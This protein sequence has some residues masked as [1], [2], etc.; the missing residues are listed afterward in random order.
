MADLVKLAETACRP[1]PSDPRTPGESHGEQTAAQEQTCLEGDA[2]QNAPQR[3]RAP[4]KALGIAEYFCECPD[5]ENLRSQKREDN[6]ED[7]R[8]NVEPHVGRNLS[9]SR[10][11]PKHQKQ[12][13]QH[14]R[15]TRQKEK[16]VRGVKQHE[17]E[18]TPAVAKTA[19]MRCAPT[20]V[21]PQRD[22]NLRDARPDLRGLDDHLERKFHTRTSQIQSVVE[23]ARESPHSAVTVSDVR[24]K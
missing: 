23:T 17:P 11:Q 2:L 16:P 15:G 9:R 4:V 7:H 21:G 3:H 8:V 5:R 22:R 6:A 20:L 18:T 24:V 10:Q 1:L 19:E 14:E 12:S 13:S